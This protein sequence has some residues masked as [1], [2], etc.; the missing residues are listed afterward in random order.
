MFELKYIYIYILYLSGTEPIVH[1][2]RGKCLLQNGKG[3]WEG[4]DVA[5]PLSTETSLKKN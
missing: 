1:V 5:V 2:L 4:M 3:T